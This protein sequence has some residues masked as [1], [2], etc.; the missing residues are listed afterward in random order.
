MLVNFLFCFQAYI[1]KHVKKRHVGDD[2][3]SSDDGK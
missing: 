1:A 3:L 2:K